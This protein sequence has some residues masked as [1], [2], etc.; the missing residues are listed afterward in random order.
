MFRLHWG[1]VTC[2]CGFGDRMFSEAVDSILK[3]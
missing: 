1:V 2:R 3:L